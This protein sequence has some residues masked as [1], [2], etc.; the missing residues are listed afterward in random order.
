MTLLHKFGFRCQNGEFST[1]T[2]SS[3]TVSDA[4]G[5]TI[6][7][8]RKCPAPNTRCATGTLSSA[9]VSSRSKSLVSRSFQFHQ[10]LSSA[11]PLSVPCPVTAMLRWR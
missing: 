8:G 1:V 7:G 5:W 6:C 2:P 3:S 10:W 9:M 4:N 11:C